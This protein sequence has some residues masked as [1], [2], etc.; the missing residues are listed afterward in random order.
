MWAHV[1]TGALVALLA[2]CEGDPAPPP[3]RAPEPVLQGEEGVLRLL[4]TG[5]MGALA[6][7]LA[8]AWM[9]TEEGK[10]WRVVVEPSVGSGGGVRAATDGAVDLGMLSRPLNARERGLGLVVATVARGAVVLAVDRAL[11]LDGLS[12]VQA[13]QL[14]RGER[15]EAGQ[16]VLQLL[17]RDREESANTAL[18]RWLPGLKPLR[19]QAYEQRRA[20]VL[21]HDETMREALVATPGGVGVVDLGAVIDG[22]GALKGL[23]LDGVPPSLEAL[24]DGR[25]RA[26]R[27][28]TFVYRPERAER[29]RGLLTFAAS[30]AALPIY[31]VSGCVPIASGKP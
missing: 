8:V 16:D 11:P 7:N 15:L 18:E 5:A 17:L 14:Y 26:T 9:G 30:P 21:Y 3:S 25:W 31:A 6:R 23:S 28:L 4:G 27:D 20:R 12:G 10:R 24:A 1:L 2:G 29:V 22:R 19:E 13:E